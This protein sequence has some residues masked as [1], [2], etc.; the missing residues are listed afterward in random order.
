MR[1][2]CSGF[3]S[4]RK[5]N[6]RSENRLIC[7]CPW[8]ILSRGIRRRRRSLSFFFEK[9]YLRLC[10]ASKYSG[11]FNQLVLQMRYSSLQ[12]QICDCKQSLLYLF[13]AKKLS[14]LYRYFIS[15]CR[16]YCD[17]LLRSFPQQ[18]YNADK[19]NLFDRTISKEL[20]FNNGSLF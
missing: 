18:G 15:Y 4:T 14:A 11:G 8:R 6:Q 3:F 17:W 20:N 10:S 16:K 1:K 19:C 2:S 12:R 7:C 9:S 5:G 13:T